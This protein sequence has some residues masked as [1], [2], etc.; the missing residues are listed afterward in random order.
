METEGPQPNVA[1]PEESVR[2]ECVDGQ[3][4]CAPI[5]VKRTVLLPIMTARTSYGIQE[6]LHSAQ[7]EDRSGAFFGSFQRFPLRPAKYMSFR[8]GRKRPDGSGGSLLRPLALD[9]HEQSE[10]A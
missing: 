3:T 9:V 7:P 6:K 8:P 2:K 4:L 10:S 1:P 5:A